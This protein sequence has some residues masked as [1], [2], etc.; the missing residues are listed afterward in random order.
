MCVY[1]CMCVFLFPFLYVLFAQ[2]SF[3]LW[4][5]LQ[6]PHT[7]A[8]FCFAYVC[9]FPMASGL[10]LRSVAVYQSVV[11]EGGPQ[12]Q[13]RGLSVRA[14]KHINKRAVNHHDILKLASN[15]SSTKQ[16]CK[17]ATSTLYPSSKLF[18]RST[19]AWLPFSSWLHLPPPEEACTE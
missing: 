17:E 6:S 2:C 13:T 9:L 16:H 7:H 14:H 19:S 3:A 15:T 10:L 8:F 12:V 4:H 1:M 5:P 18:V 11:G